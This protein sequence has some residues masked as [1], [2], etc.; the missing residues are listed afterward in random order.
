VLTQSETQKAAQKS[1]LIFLEAELCNV[2]LAELAAS[3]LPTHNVSH[4]VNFAT[5]IQNNSRTAIDKI[6][7]DNSRINLSSTFPIINALSN[8][9]AK[10]LTIKNK[11]ATINKFPLKEQQINR[12][13]QNHELSDST[14]KI[15]LGICL[16]R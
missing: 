7:V 3:L 8:H 6:F 10:I 12:Q 2:S 1:H 13:R 14:K 4:T 11:Y 9:D 15:N 16:Y 5:R